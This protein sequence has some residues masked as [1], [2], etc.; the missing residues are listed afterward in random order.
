MISNPDNNDRFSR[1]QAD[2]CD[3]AAWGTQ[4]LEFHRETKNLVVITSFMAY[5]LTAEQR[6]KLA[7]SIHQLCQ[8]FLAGNGET[9][10]WM[11][12][13]A[14]TSRWKDATFEFD[15]LWLSQF[16][17]EDGHFSGKSIARVNNDASEGW[18]MD[19]SSKCSVL[20]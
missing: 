13:G 6:I 7:R 9:V 18:A 4:A 16:K 20:V 8:R 14:E 5:Q 17:F 19:G 2:A 10:T 3:Q 15:N 1:L 12:Q 11:N